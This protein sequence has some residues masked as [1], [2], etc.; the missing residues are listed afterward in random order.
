MDMD[1]LTLRYFDAEMRYLRE[2]GKEFAEAF[3]D[4]AAHLNLDKPGAQD[5]YVERLFEGFA[6]LMGRLREKLDDDLPELTEGLVSLLWPHYLRTIPSLSIVELVPDLAQIKRSERIAKGFEILSQPIGPQR[7]RCRYTTTQ[8]VTLQPLAVTCVERDHEPDGRS[9]LR[10]RFA[11]SESV[12]WAQIDLSCLPLYLNADAPL[13]SA[14][15]QAL[16]L[17]KQTMYVRMAGQSGRL[18][19]DGHFAA[20]GFADEDRLWPKGDSAFSGYQLLLEYFTFRE[21]FMFVTLCGLDQLTIESNAPWFDLEVVLREPWPHAFDLG[22]EH[23]RLHAVPVINL[24][25]LEA[26]PLELDPLQTDYLLRPMRLQD[27]HLEIYSVDQVTASKETE[28]LDYVPFTSFRHKGGMLR[29]EAPERYFHTR[30]KRAANGLHDT[31]LI[32]GGEGFDEDRLQTLERLSLSLTGTHGQLPRKALQGAVLDTT[33]QSTQLGLRVRN[34]CAP[35]LPCYPPN[36]DRFHW[37]ILS[38]LGSN[39]LPMLDSAEVLRGTLALYDWAGSEL[40]RRRL[41][42]IVEVKHHLVQRFE[43]GFLM[44]GVDIEITLDASGF[45]GEGDISLFGEMLNRFFA[46]YA[47][48]HLYTQLTLVLQPTGACLR[49]SE[50]HSQRIPG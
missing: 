41:A 16:T 8:D 19:V 15:H 11:R 50:N 4:R 34:L 49:W 35:T 36:R 43:K 33:V 45:S 25:V 5:P 37:R 24:F 44:R 26:D 38:H 12:P 42:A 13:A 1:N 10:L 40:N 7:T 29:D 3:P 32:L 6:F 31:W 23:I 30:L 46:L 9:L 28:R 22:V 18:N 47:D 2:A 20:K 27:G 21:K 48:I 39:F 14:L 17:N